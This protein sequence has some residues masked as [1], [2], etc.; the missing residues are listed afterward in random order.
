[1]VVQFRNPRPSNIR[2]KLTAA[3]FFALAPQLGL[4]VRQV[5]SEI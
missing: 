5:V 4:S 3:L 1:M 2:L